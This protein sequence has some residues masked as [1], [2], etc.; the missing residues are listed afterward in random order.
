M[1]TKMKRAFARLSV[2]E[3][4]RELKPQ[5][6]WR[7]IEKVVQDKFPECRKG[8]KLND[9]LI[10]PEKV[11]PLLETP[12]RKEVPAILCK[13]SDDVNNDRLKGKRLVREAIGKSKNLFLQMALAEAYQD[14]G[15]N[16]AQCNPVTIIKIST[17]MRTPGEGVQI[18]DIETREYSRQELT[19]LRNDCAQN[20]LNDAKW[21]L[22]LWNKGMY[23]IRLSN[24]EMKNLNLSIDQPNVAEALQFY[25]ETENTV[26]TVFEWIA[27]AWIQ[28]FPVLDGEHR[29]K[30][31]RSLGNFAY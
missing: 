10:D 23:G 15:N 8:T 28:A 6:P 1:F 31:L 16:M 22:K 3:D 30:V 7:N 26:R 19:S 11:Q 25:L 5:S 9:L 20:G 4:W 13:V 2:R 14:S 21:L 24:Q 17:P 29:K 27:M 12:H 18:R